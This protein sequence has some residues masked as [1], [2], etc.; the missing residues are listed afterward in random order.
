M[1]SRGEQIA[2]RAMHEKESCAFPCD[3]NFFICEKQIRQIANSI[4][5]FEFTNPVLISSGSSNPPAP[6]RQPGLL[7]I[8]SGVREPA[9]FRVKRARRGLWRVHSRRVTEHAF[10]GPQSQGCTN[11]FATPVAMCGD[12]NLGCCVYG[13]S[14]RISGIVEYNDCPIIAITALIDK[15]IAFLRQKTPL[16]LGERRVLASKVKQAARQ[17]KIDISLMHIAATLRA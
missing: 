1:A 2:N 16:P 10:I 8:S 11:Q 9:T 5:P 4:E 14:V 6:G 3:L 12:R 15:D 17:K 7:S 13:P